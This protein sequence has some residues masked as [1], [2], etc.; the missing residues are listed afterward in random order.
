MLS[1]PDEI[2]TPVLTE[3]LRQFNQK[4][5]GPGSHQHEAHALSGGATIEWPPASKVD[6][7]FFDGLKYADSRVLM[8]MGVPPVMVTLLEGSHD[9]NTDAQIT[10]FW[11]NCIIPKLRKSCSTIN[12]L[13]SPRYGEDIVVSF[14]KSAI[15]ALRQAAQARGS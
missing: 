2:A 9:Q 6:M 13:I 3:M 5:A 4:F 10:I 12:R 15:T 8:G 1:F 7:G 11:N 14:D